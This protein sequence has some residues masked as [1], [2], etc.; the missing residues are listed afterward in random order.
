VEKGIGAGLEVFQCR[1]TCI[2]LREYLL[3][4]EDF[5]RAIFKMEQTQDDN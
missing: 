4:Y 3:V 1:M 5:C 2:Y